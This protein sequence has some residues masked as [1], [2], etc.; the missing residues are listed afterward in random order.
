[1]KPDRA[2]TTREARVDQA[3][4]MARGICLAT[5][6]KPSCICQGDPTRCHAAA[7][8]SDFAIAALLGLERAGYRVEKQA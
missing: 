3:T 5:G 2:L 6:P 4:V 1:M 8:Y 7:F